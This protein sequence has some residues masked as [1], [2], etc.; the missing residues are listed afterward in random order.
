MRPL[1]RRLT[2][3]SPEVVVLGVENGF[4]CP[5]SGEAVSAAT[6]SALICPGS[7]ETGD[8]VAG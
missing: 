7:G 3:A 8:V 4:V 2:A 6:F 1:T 5:V